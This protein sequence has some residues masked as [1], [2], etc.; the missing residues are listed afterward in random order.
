[1]PE[2][3]TIL[4]AARTLRAWLDGREVT[5]ARSTALGANAERLVGR[6]IVTVEARGKH[7]LIRLDDGVV[8]HTHLRMT[9]SWH[10]YPAGD[11][12][13]RP[14]RQARLVIEA[15]D[16]VAVCF[17]APVV[18]LL[19]PA[20]VLLHPSLRG[21]GPDALAEPLDLDGVRLRARA[22]PRETPIGD[23]LLDQRVVAGIGNIYRCESLFLRG[24]H[25]ATPLGDLGDDE[26]DALVASAA[27]LLHE[28]V[29]NER[30]PAWVYGRANRPCRRCGTR[31]RSQRQGRDARLV[32]WCPR[33]Q[34]SP[35][36]RGG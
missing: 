5:A 10:V 35:L 36:D 17:N 18:E 25:P 24:L 1:M 30:G 9:G 15:G 6:T 26:L 11:P 14:E 32:Y 7:L 33:C 8:V 28:G 34:V 16:R 13:Q 27:S 20:D 31:V 19:A 21:L 12:W 29:R 4:R 23:V 2:G 3:D 22:V